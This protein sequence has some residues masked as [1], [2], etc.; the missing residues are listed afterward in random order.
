MWGGVGRECVGD[1]R[2]MGRGSEVWR[3]EGM[4]GW[5]CGEGEVGEVEMGVGGWGES[6]EI[7]LGEGRTLCREMKGSGDGIGDWVLARRE[8]IRQRKEKG[9]VDREKW[10]RRL[11]RVEEREII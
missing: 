3:R 10:S 9:L 7:R 1:D 2:G 4:C 8:G 5:R 11:G 6:G